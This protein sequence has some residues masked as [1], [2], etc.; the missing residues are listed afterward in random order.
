MQR[1]EPASSYKIWL[2]S[3]GTR[4]R[5]ADPEN[6]VFMYLRHG[7]V[8]RVCVHKEMKGTQTPRKKVHGSVLFTVT[9]IN[10]K[11][12]CAQIQK[13]SEGEGLHL[14]EMKASLT[15]GS[16][17]TNKNSINNIYTRKQ[18]ILSLSDAGPFNRCAR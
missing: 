4:L 18:S 11:L 16:R 9:R 15:T 2:T 6:Y 7:D 12:L 8:K 1:E 3:E 5:N 14:I 10:R 17:S 13:I